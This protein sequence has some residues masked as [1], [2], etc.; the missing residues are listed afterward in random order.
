MDNM[1]ALGPRYDLMPVQS[2]S[3]RANSL[4]AD[5]IIETIR[6]LDAGTFPKHW[7]GKLVDGI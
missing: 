1:E 7:Q 2:E 3:Q 4:V 5:Q 6:S